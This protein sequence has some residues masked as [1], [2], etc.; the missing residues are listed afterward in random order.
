MIKARNIADGAVTASKLAIKTVA[1]TVAIGETAGTA[2][3]AAGSVIMGIYPTSNQDQLIDSVVIATT[4]LTVTL[5]AAATAENVF[6]VS[7]LN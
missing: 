5:A 4:T 2:T 1:V 7:I 6:A 3:V